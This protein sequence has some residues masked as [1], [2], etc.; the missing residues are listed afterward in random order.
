MAFHKDRHK[1]MD[2]KGHRHIL[3]IN[4]SGAKGLPK[5]ENAG[6]VPKTG[7]SPS[8]RSIFAGDVPKIGTSPAPRSYFS[9]VRSRI[10]S[11]SMEKPTMSMDFSCLFSWG[12]AER[13]MTARPLEKESTRPA[14]RRFRT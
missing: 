10:S 2:S 14:G 8:I 6:D 1:S 9:T 12:M 4:F 13:L 11:E 3:R 7:T 5:G